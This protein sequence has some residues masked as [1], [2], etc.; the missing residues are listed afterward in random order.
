M[1][2]FESFNRSIDQQNIAAYFS[3]KRL[4]ASSR[5]TE[6]HFLK[7]KRQST[8][9]GL[10]ITYFQNFHPP[11]TSYLSFQ[12]GKIFFLNSFRIKKA[13]YLSELP[14]YRTQ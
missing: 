3:L 6:R 4:Q 9:R 7:N 5:W 13:D 2:L 10:L 11:F 12:T 8:I 1:N 14:I